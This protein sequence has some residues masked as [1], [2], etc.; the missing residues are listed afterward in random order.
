VGIINFVPRFVP[1]FSLMVKPI[2]NLLKK[3]RSFSWIGDVENSFIRIKKEI[4]STPVLAKQDFEKD[5]IIYT[6]ATEEEFYDI[7]LQCDDQN[8]E[9]LVAYMSQILSY[10]EFKYSYINFF[11]LWLKLWRNFA[12]LF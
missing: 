8:N 7:L 3:D 12:T 10:D 4:S 1:N 11:F 9:K 5:F 2:H 6:N